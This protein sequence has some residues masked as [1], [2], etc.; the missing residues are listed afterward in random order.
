[1]SDTQ[2]QKGQQRLRAEA[3]AWL[4]PG[5]ALQAIFVTQTGPSG[6]GEWGFGSLMQRYWVIAVTDRNV[7]VGPLGVK[8]SPTRLP[9][10]PFEM[11]DAPTGGSSFPVTIGG[12]RQ[13]SAR[14]QFEIVAAANALL[15]A[16][17]GTAQPGGAVAPE[18]AARPQTPADWYAD[19]LGRHEVRYWDGHQWTDNVADQGVQAED[20]VSTA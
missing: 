10:V 16:G 15:R 4:D 18:E 6:I 5:E 7:V 8:G 9:R 17:Q 20:P 19:P 11:P 2:L 1:M 14:E 3:Q 12:Q 13:R